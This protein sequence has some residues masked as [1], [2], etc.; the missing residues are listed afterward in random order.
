MPSESWAGVPGGCV[1]AQ[2][3]RRTPVE[4][5][6][7][8]RLRVF[9]RFQAPAEHEALVDGLLTE[10]RLRARIAVSPRLI[11]LHPGFCLCLL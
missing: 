10:H 11:S 8:A 7:H 3:R 1:Q 4:K 9:A 5:E 6:L 2:D